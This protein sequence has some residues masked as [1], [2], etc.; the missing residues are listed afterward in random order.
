[1]TIV[2][3]HNCTFIVLLHSLGGAAFLSL[4]LSDYLSPFLLACI[5]HTDLSGRLAV[6]RELLAAPGVCRPCHRGWL[7][8]EV[9][10]VFSN[11]YGSVI[12]WGPFFWDIFLPV[13]CRVLACPKAKCQ[14][15][16]QSQMGA[17]GTAEESTAT[18]GAMNAHPHTLRSHHRIVEPQIM[19]S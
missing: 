19:E 13:N 17:L 1:M 3:L 12:L 5:P 10:E 16:H 6:L 11:P 2:L 18:N 4:F 14:H 7:G 15:S 9:W 8:L